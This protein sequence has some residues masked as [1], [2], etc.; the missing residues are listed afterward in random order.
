MSKSDD[1]KQVFPDYTANRSDSS[2]TSPDKTVIR[3]KDTTRVNKKSPIQESITEREDRTVIRKVKQTPT[4]QTVQ[5]S[6]SAKGKMQA[7]RPDVTRVPVSKRSQH[8]PD[9][10]RIPSPTPAT[11][12]ATSGG[13]GQT[14]SQHR[15]LKNRFLLEKVLGV[16]GMGVVYKAKDRLKVEAH[17]RD[18]Y[19][20]I[21]VLSEEFKSHPDAFISLQ[22]ES[23]KAQR[24]S[25]PNI[26]KVYDFDRDGDVVFMTMEYMEGKPLDQMIK[27]Y[28]ATGLP[29]MM[30]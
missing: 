13:N 26:V 25:Q 17:D 9:A 23:R 7:T 1:E 11:A 20:A 8:K 6:A 16:G 22:R 14:N 10:T 29:W 2:I 15:I 30:G 24:L 5:R 3:S 27:Q 4:D 21:K 18:P 28:N 19:V 12:R